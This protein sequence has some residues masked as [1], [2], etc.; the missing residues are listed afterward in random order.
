MGNAIAAAGGDAPQ[1][2]AGRAVGARTPTDP[3]GAA[4]SLPSGGA[5]G[6]PGAAD[7][8]G[9]HADM[10]SPAGDSAP[11][12]ALQPEGATAGPVPPVLPTP[13]ATGS[14]APV[15]HPEA[16]S[17]PAQAGDHGAA[18]PDAATPPASAPHAAVAHVAA[19]APGNAH[20]GDPHV[21]APPG[22]SH[23]GDPHADDAHG[24]PSTPA[25]RAMSASATAPAFAETDVEHHVPVQ[26]GEPPQVRAQRIAQ[27]RQQ[28]AQDRAY[29][30]GRVAAFSSKQRQRIAAI[31]QV[32]PHID[33]S[34]DSSERQAASR[35]AQSA[36]AQTTAVRAAV[37]GALAQAGNAAVAAR[38]Q[39][40]ATF[41]TTTQAIEAATLAARTK[42]EA[43]YQQAIAAAGSAEQRQIAEVGRL[44]TQADGAF[45]AAAASAGAHAMSISAEHAAG[46]RSHKIN[47]DDSFLDG[48]LTD[49]RC[50]AQADAAEK[51]GQA[52]RD[53]LAKEGAKQS[54]QLHQRRPTDEAAVHQVAD[55]ARRNLAT[56]HT[57][58]LQA[59]DQGRQQA[60]DSARKVRDGAL[61]GTTQTL[62]QTQMAL[63]QHERAQLA[64]IRQQAATQ[65]TS[66]R[67]QHTKAAAQLHKNIDE[68][69]TDLDTGLDRSLAA[70]HQ[71]E[72]P[73][74]A[75]VDQTLAH[76]DGMIESQI[77][78]LHTDLDA[79]RG[80]SAQ[81]LTRSGSAGA[82]GIDH[83][84]VSA[85]SSAHQTGS[86][87]SQALAQGGHAAAASLQQIS[88]MHQQAMSSSVT[89]ATTGNAT[90][91]KGVDQAYTQLSQNL[92]QGMQH[93][94][95]AVRTGLIA[96]V[97]QQIGGT[98][99]SEAAKA[100]DQVKPRWQSVLK[101][102]IIIAVILVV[103][104]V[105]GPMV[106]GAVAGL[107]AGLGASAAVAGVVGA[108]VG[109]AIVG[110]GTAAVTTV[111]DNGFSGKTGWHL[112]DGVGTAMAWG[113]LG[114]AL[115]GGAG[116]LL[117]GPMEAMPALARYAVQV[118]V[119]NVINTGLS[120]AQGNFSWQNF[121]ASFLL[122]M[123][124]N[125]IAMHPQIRGMSQNAM[126][127]GY[128]AGFEGGIGIRNQLPGAP[129][130]PATSIPATA[131]N[132]VAQGDT[133]GP[134][135]PY[136][137]N[138]NVRGGGHVP[139]EI[140]PRADAQGTP[141]TTTTTDPVSGVS[142]EQFTRPNG[143][144]T[145]KSLFPPSTTRADVDA[146]GNAG[147][148]RA[149]SNAPGSSFTPPTAPNS[150]GHFTATVMGPDGHPILIEGYYRPNPAGGFDIQ[151]VFPST[152]LAAG[153]IPVPGGTGLGGSRTVPPP[154]Y[155][156]PPLPT[157]DRD[158]Q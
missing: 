80:Q 130:P 104:I 40:A 151:S 73:Q 86:G 85:A 29:A 142:I 62:V 119:D 156:H 72:V 117:S 82:Q 71:A 55:E 19:A 97:D 39:I 31:H 53:E 42:I 157:Q 83:V 109:G 9:A 46:Y 88:A 2:I 127:R 51:V 92:Q 114:G 131:M 67:T 10:T 18:H 135:S 106:I 21:T 110:A 115:G 152:N 122:S 58:S 41:A 148:Q 99:T 59:L 124:V 144:T 57:A 146:M 4:P 149:L 102:V 35:V 60:L 81:A 17:A 121:G 112:F 44:Y 91:T 129:P 118:G 143:A 33:Q 108:V 49:N 66:L 93:N 139:G 52:Y 89:A 14:A 113:A 96:A 145:D 61:T 15:L 107:A 45:H 90:V 140:I 100:Y 25:P 43:S 74:R 155:I 103:A 34:L 36:A 147:L 134:G 6:A 94:A 158:Q 38:A 54:T 111:I 120:V 87:S 78:K 77:G 30:T 69:S 47:R 95:D 136:A 8:A 26:P 154:I 98:I 48:P 133:A 23:P 79:S 24:P 1:R 138:W 28:L 84:G 126:S 32:R 116:A 37:T 7:A 76:A 150:N 64:A 16:T 5:P 101:W 125:G 13:L 50:E 123:F 11:P 153:T 68:A 70:L 141:H 65:R 75:A 63:R 56:A 137:G 27:L 20:G 128:G 132:H 3:T 105:L 22:D 12:R